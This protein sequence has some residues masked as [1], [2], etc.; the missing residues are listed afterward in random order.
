MDCS[1]VPPYMG[2]CLNLLH[3]AQIVK[4][5]FLLSSASL[6]RPT[7][8]GLL[9]SQDVLT[10]DSFCAALHKHG[11]PFPHPR[12]LCRWPGRWRANPHPRVVASIFR[13]PH[14]WCRWKCAMH[15]LHLLA[16]SA[17]PLLPEPRLPEKSVVNFG[18]TTF[19]DSMFFSQSPTLTASWLP[20]MMN[21][22]DP[23]MIL[24]WLFSCTPC[25][26]ILT[27]LSRY[28]CWFAKILSAL[29]KLSHTPCGAACAPKHFCISTVQRCLV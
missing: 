22:S 28:F 12:R 24:R 9:L 4:K 8:F 27:G 7:C 10:I 11:L 16:M 21:F 25:T 5:T 17:H 2:S 13:L 19:L 15:L 18:F 20:A 6:K 29:T 26:T 23:P 1:E 3:A 14:S